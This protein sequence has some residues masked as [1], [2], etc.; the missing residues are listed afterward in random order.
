MNPVPSS[1]TL[2][3]PVGE[4]RRAAELTNLLL[5]FLLSQ[6]AKVGVEEGKTR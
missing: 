2:L 3:P 5:A 1:L 4:G 6:I